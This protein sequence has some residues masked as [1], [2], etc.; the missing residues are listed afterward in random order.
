MCVCATSTEESGVRE[1]LGGPSLAESLLSLSTL[2]PGLSLPV[3][4]FIQTEMCSSVYLPPSAGWHR[5]E[6]MAQ[7]GGSGFSCWG[8]QEQICPTQRNCGSL[9]VGWTLCISLDV[10]SVEWTLLLEKNK[11]SW[12]LKAIFFRDPP[13]R[14]GGFSGKPFSVMDRRQAF[15]PLYVWRDL[16][17]GQSGEE[18]RKRRLIYWNPERI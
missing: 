13:R 1:K 16:D 6:A 12:A 10:N 15:A 2:S 5:K 3:G 11:Q 17:S 9:L 7:T 8:K 4:F 14:W 18:T